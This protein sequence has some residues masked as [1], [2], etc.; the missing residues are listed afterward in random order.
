MHTQPLESPP[1]PHQ[2]AHDSCVDI[3]IEPPT[4][5]SYCNWVTFTKRTLK[6]R[7]ISLL[8]IKV[9]K[10]ESIINAELSQLLSGAR[11]DQP[12]FVIPKELIL[13]TFH[14]LFDKIDEW[15]GI[16]L[17]RKRI[18]IYAYKDYFKVSKSWWDQNKRKLLGPVFW[19]HVFHRIQSICKCVKGNEIQWRY[20]VLKMIRLIFYGTV[21]YDNTKPTPLINGGTMLCSSELQQYLSK[22]H[23]VMCEINHLHRTTKSCTAMIEK[24]RTLLNRAVDV[25]QMIH[26]QS[27][28][29]GPN[30][31]NH[32]IYN[33]HAKR[34]QSVVNQSK[35]RNQ[36][37]NYNDG[38]PSNYN[39]NAQNVYANQPTQNVNSCINSAAPN[40]PNLMNLNLNHRHHDPIVF[41]VNN[42]GPSPF[43][44][45]V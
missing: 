20:N 10:I 1:Q 39:T 44:F 36:N 28:D 21:K 11:Y 14:C 16:N 27:V 26:Y 29:N 12:K 32:I 38:A 35:Q 5:S 42:G 25:M 18:P 31:E 15:N 23:P 43:V 37:S 24:V 2:T 34:T 8:S 17:E 13:H 4:G 19:I 6:E 30:Y 9:A 3:A 41:L 7:E 45:I 22:L 40:R 33:A